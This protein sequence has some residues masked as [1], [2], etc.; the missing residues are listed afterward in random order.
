MPDRRNRGSVAARRADHQACSAALVSCRTVAR[1]RL[2]SSVGGLGRFYLR[3]SR[4]EGPWEGSVTPAPFQTARL[5]VPTDPRLD[6]TAYADGQ[7]TKGVVAVL[8]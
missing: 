4:G 2:L 1:Y 3:L 6:L 8:E 5:G 7:S